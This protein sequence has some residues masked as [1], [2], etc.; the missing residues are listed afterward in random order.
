[1]YRLKKAMMEMNI[2]QA[3]KNAEYILKP[4]GNIRKL[5]TCGMAYTVNNCFYQIGNIKVAE[6]WVINKTNLT[7]VLSL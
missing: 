1:M 7:K 6:F 4:C 3:V 5:Q 2:E